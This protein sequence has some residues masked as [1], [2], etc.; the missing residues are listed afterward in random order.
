M[1]L[2]EVVVAVAAVVALAG[3]ARADDRGAFCEVTPCLPGPVTRTRLTA[4]RKVGK[5]VCKRGEELGVDRGGRVA[6]C[7]TAAAADVGGVPVAA[8]AYTLFYP[9]GRVYQTHARR[10]FT[11][12]RGDGSTVRCGADVIALDPRGH[13]TYC[14]LAARWPGPPAGRVGAGIAFHPDGRLAGLTLDAPYRAAGLAFPAGASV[15]WDRAGHVIGGYTRDPIQ[16]GPLSIRDD[17]ALYPGG[18]LREIELAAA[19][20]IQGHAFPRGAELAFRNDGT[21]ARATYVEARGFMI[22]G[23]PWT[24]TR[25]TTYSPSGAVATTRLDHWVAPSRPPRLRP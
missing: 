14:E 24:D 4:P 12:T 16:A 18:R 3:P 19:A 23:E 9:T 25:I 10:A 2:T 21:L 7:T 15:R 5:L 20:T 13:V 11:G 22:H 1:R 8:G 6:F 17:L